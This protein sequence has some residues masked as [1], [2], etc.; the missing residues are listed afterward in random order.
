LQK[1]QTSHLLCDKLIIKVP[2]KSRLILRRAFSNPAIGRGTGCCHAREAW[3]IGAETIEQES[4]ATMK[5]PVHYRSIHMKITGEPCHWKD[6]LRKSLAALLACW[7]AVAGAGTA[8][9]IT[10]QPA[11]Q[12][13]LTGGTVVFTVEATGQ[14]PLKYQ[15]QRDGTNLSNNVVVT[16]AGTGTPLFGDVLSNGIPA[17]SAQLSFPTGVALDASGNLFISA[18]N[19]ANVPFSLFGVVQEVN[20]QGI[21][22]AMAGSGGSAL[23]DGGEAQNAALGCPDGMTMDAGSNLFI[24]DKMANRVREVNA[25]GVITTVAGNGST[26][27]PSVDFGLGGPPTPLLTHLFGGD[28]GQATNATLS[29]PCDVAEDSFGNLYI[30]DALNE[31]I[32]KV[33]RTGKITTVAG[34]GTYAPMT[35]IDDNGVVH[36]TTY[37]EFGGY[38]GDGGPAVNAALNHPSGVAVDNV[39]NLYIAD[40]ANNLV[41]KVDATTQ[42]ITTV[43]G[44]INPI[45]GWNEGGPATSVNIYSPSSVKV[46]NAGNLYIASGN[47]MVA[48]G[49]NNIYKVDANG[50]ITTVAGTGA[51]GYSGD[52]IPATD[53]TFN[54]IG[55]I[56]FDASGNLYVVDSGNAVVR[57]IGLGGFPSLVLN[58]VTT[59]NEGSYDVIVS[60]PWGSVTSRVATLTIVYPPVITSQP[61]NAVVLQ[62]SNALFSVTATGSAPLT[63]NW[64]LNSTQLVQSG[65]ANT[66]SIPN[67]L[68]ANGGSYA[69]V[70]TNPWARGVSSNATLTVVYPPVI[71]TDLVSQTNLMGSNTTFAVTVTGTPPMTYQW[72]HDGTNIANIPIQTFAGGWEAGRGTNCA[73]AS[74]CGLAVDTF[75]NLYIADQDNNTILKLDP[76]G[77]VTT[78]AGVGNGPGAGTALFSGDGGPATNAS[79]NYPAGIAFDVA[80]NLYI[81]DLYNYRI[82]KVDT[83]GIITTVA[84]GGMAGASNG[85]YATNARLYQPISVVLDATNNL[86]I[87]DAGLNAVRRVDTNSII[88]TVAGGGAN[89]PAVGMQATNAY[90]SY[91]RFAQVATDTTGNLYIAGN[92]YVWVVAPNGII[93]RLLKNGNGTPTGVAVAANGL[94]YFA[95]SYQDNIV[96]VDSLNNITV[97]ATSLGGSGYYLNSL[98]LD[99]AGNVYCA[100]TDGFVKMLDTSNHL[101]TVA[102]NG[103]AMYSGDGGQA[104]AASL[105]DP[106]GLASDAIGN[107]YIAD[108]NNQRA[109]K[110]DTNGMITSVAGGGV[111]GWPLAASLSSIAGVACDGQGNLFVSAYEAVYEDSNGVFSTV[112]NRNNGWGFYGDGGP[113]TN[114][115]LANPEGLTVDSTGNLFIAD[116]SDTRVRKVDAKGIITT[117]AGGG[118]LT[119]NGSI[120]TNANIWTPTDVAVNPTGLLYISSGHFAG[121]NSFVYRV[122]ADGTITTIAGGTGGLGD[123]GLAANASV[124]VPAGL[125][126]DPAGNLFIADSD[127]NRVRRVDTNGIITT[128]AGTGVEGYSGDGGQATNAWLNEPVGLAFDPAGNLYVADSAN[129]RVREVLFTGS[130]TLILDHANPAEAGTYQVIV[131]NPWATATSS[132]VTLTLTSTPIIFRAMARNPD[133]SITFTGTGNPSI[134][135]ILQTTTSLTPPVTWLSIATNIS[136]SS[137]Q[138]TF[139]ET[140]NPAYHG[141]FFRVFTH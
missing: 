62:H 116:N 111:N 91:A 61:T 37:T 53:A 54:G 9:T 127:N 28:G 82:R 141:S 86:Y 83:N 60:N 71:T 3:G 45:L 130:P 22:N 121:G 21:I 13:S 84:G 42:N 109:R 67:V 50:N 41:R 103:Y 125:A 36:Y 74:P 79:L 96:T 19:T 118:T 14:G 85:G 23:G 68:G 126:F 89:A 97:V 59:A 110:V 7:P 57:E 24:A 26:N 128:I 73:L 138:W 43:A 34:N 81:A 39:G 75:T 17:L 134:P 58:S 139:M 131:S 11:D 27:Y 52:E 64:Y 15:W 113:A 90:M 55:Q 124:N 51:K 4:E 18:G 114:A 33:D 78:F 35:Y 117:A 120:A 123:G 70:V 119:T 137:G 47:N 105:S 20:A 10:T 93:T 112:V 95:D 133:G 88:T 29:V 104:T 87:V 136:S 107:I 77:N 8:P 49:N 38:S 63:Y 129:N 135:H 115:G 76:S 101:H 56:N 1:T 122:N 12:Y 80:N 25:S 5:K 66:L 46:D 72:L 48:P 32:R 98:A 92:G 44:N 30:A 100:D 108:Y 16:V 99:P 2:E 140:N 102:G 40:T 69:V 106:Q 94:V 31:R 65:P 132:V 6:L